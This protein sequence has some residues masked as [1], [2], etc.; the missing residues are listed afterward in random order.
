MDD[1]AIMLDGFAVCFRFPKRGE[2][3]RVI[4]SDINKA[5]HFFFLA[6]FALS[7]NALAVGAP[8][9]PGSR[10]FSPDPAS[11]RFLFR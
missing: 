6:V 3:L 10:I 1:G 5:G 7:R 8:F 9:E 11:M 2:S 4:V